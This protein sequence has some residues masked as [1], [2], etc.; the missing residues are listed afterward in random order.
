[1]SSL[2]FSK[3]RYVIVPTTFKDGETTEF[4]LRLFTDHDADVRELNEDAPGKPWYDACG[5]AS[6]PCLLTR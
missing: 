2:R 3:G 6:K 5:M 1:M 4:L